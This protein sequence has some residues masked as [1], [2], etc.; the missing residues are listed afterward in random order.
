M[1]DMPSP[2]VSPTLRPDL[3]IY[4]VHTQVCRVTAATVPSP[5]VVNL[6]LSY[7]Q[8]VVPSTL[9]PR[10]REVCLV[11]DLTGAGLLPGEYICRLVGSYTQA[12]V[13]Y[14]VYAA[15]A[16]GA[17][18]EPPIDD[19]CSLAGMRDTDCLLVV[20]P[21]GSVVLMYSGGVWTSSEEI[22]F[23]YGDS[24]AS[25]V[26]EFYYENGALHLKLG[27]VELLNCAD[28]CFTG[29]PLT[30]H[31]PQSAGTPCNGET[32]TLCVVCVPCGASGGSGGMG[33]GTGSGAN[34]NTCITFGGGGSGSGG[35]TPGDCPCPQAPPGTDPT[36]L[37]WLL[38]IT[39]VTAGSCNDLSNVNGNWVLNYQ[40]NC[41]WQ[42]MQVTTLSCIRYVGNLPLWTLAITPGRGMVVTQQGDYTLNP[43]LIQGVIPSGYACCGVNSGALAGGVPNVGPT[44]AYDSTGATF[45]L[46]PINACGFGITTA[47]DAILNGYLHT[48]VYVDTT[49]TLTLVAGSSPPRWSGASGST[50][51][52]VVCSPDG[53]FTATVTDGLYSVSGQLTVIVCIP[54][55]TLG[56][57]LGSLNANIQVSVVP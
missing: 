7:V 45:M 44:G 22:E 29:G 49:I 41:I 36:P 11:N 10:D 14:P 55:C 42:T 18:S 47:F 30:G 34:C 2:L 8:Q 56:G 27:G 6:Y 51:M 23:P 9:L 38:T 52:S 12:G 48:T 50:E 1:A 37:Q 5:S 46:T 57:L 43:G 32:F 21:Y 26:L 31:E 53:M 39:G 25:A 17:G 20:G 35:L 54:C 4:P 15:V 33:S 13:T 40:S 28:G 24:I 16:G 3:P 19:Y